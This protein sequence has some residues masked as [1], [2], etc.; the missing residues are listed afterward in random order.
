MFELS[1]EHV[2]NFLRAYGWLPEQGKVTTARFERAVKAYQRH[3][4]LVVDGEV[5]P[6]TTRSLLETRFCAAPDRLKVRGLAAKWPTLEVTYW[7]DAP[8]SPLS[9]TQTWEAFDGAAGD[10]SRPRT[11][12]KMRRATSKSSA[13]IRAVVGRI[14]GRGNTLAWSELPPANPADQKYDDGETWDFEMAQAVA[15]HE[16]GHA[17]GLDHDSQSG[18]LMSPTFSRRVLKA[19]AR[20][21]KRMQALYGVAPDEPGPPV[22]TPGGIPT[23]EELRIEWGGKRYTAKGPMKAA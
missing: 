21:I 10:W 15:E 1:Q 16:M 18:Q 2:E 12:L 14:D 19:Q 6:Q 3:F 23:V 22:P 13:M 7:I 4:K 17:L 9:M 11:A 20:D 8:L 5:G